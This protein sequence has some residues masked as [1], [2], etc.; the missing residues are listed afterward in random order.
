VAV[1][2]LLGAGGF[3]AVWEAGEGSS[4][5][6]KVAHH[7]ASSRDSGFEKEAEALTRVGPPHTPRL[8]EAGV[9]ADGRPYLLQE[10][11]DT[12]SL[13]AMLASREHP[14]EGDALLEAAL[15][16]VEA[17]EAMHAANVLHRDLKPENIF[18]KGLPP[19]AML[20]D[21][22]TA[23]SLEAERGV[24]PPGAVGS[25]E[26]MSPE[27]LGSEEPLGPEADLYA[28]GVILFELATLRLPFTGNAHELEYAH[29]NLRPLRPSQF[30][31]VG[32]GL[33]D[34]IL[35]CLQ[36]RPSQR[37]P[38]ASA[39]KAALHQ[40][41]S[42]PTSTAPQAKGPAPAPAGGRSKLTAALV[43]F[44][45][46]HDAASLQKLIVSAGGHIAHRSGA[47]CVA[48]FTPE[49][50]ENLGR[51]ALHC[52]STLV[53]RGACQKALVDLAP[54]LVSRRPEGAVL[55]ASPTFSQPDRYPSSAD[56]DGILV[57][58]A[59]QEAIGDIEGEPCAERAGH[60]LYRRELAGEVHLTSAAKSAKLIGREALVASLLDEVARSLKAGESAVSMVVGAPGMGKSHLAR[61]V[62]DRLQRTSPGLRT[63]R[64]VAREPVGRSADE[65][66]KDFLTRVLELPAGI[67]SEE[68]RQLVEARL[69]DLGAA[70][71]VALGLIFGWVAPDAPEVRALRAAPGA[72]QAALARAGGEAVRRLVAQGPVCIWLDD[73]QWF[74]TV[75]LEALDQ[76]SVASGGLHVLA[77]GRPESAE[78]FAS[79]GRRAR[80]AYRHE[81]AS[82]DRESAFE[83]CRALLLP[84]ALVA[85]TD[86]ERIVDRV[87]GV[88]LLMVELVRGLK[89][90]GLLRRPD[91][92]GAWYVAAE[93]LDTIP[94]LPLLE[95]LTLRQMASLTADLAA[96]ARLLAVLSPLVGPA[97]VEGVLA[98]LEPEMAALFP[99]D[100]RAGLY[101]LREAKVVV[102]H[103]NGELSLRSGLSSAVI[104][105][106]LPKPTLTCI[107]RAALRYYQ[108]ASSADSV[109][110]P[111]LAFHAALA[112]EKQ[113]AMRTCLQLAEQARARHHYLEA[114][115]YYSR[116]AEH[117]VPGHEAE[118]L[119]VYRGRGVVR[120]RAG[121]V[122]DSLGDFSR[123]R[124]LAAARGDLLAQTEVLLDESMA[125]DWMN[126][127]H[128]SKL[129][130]EEAK[131][132]SPTPAPALLSARI[133]QA[134]GRSAC[135]FS[136]DRA[137]VSLYREAAD[138]AQGLGEDAYEVR[139]SV[140]VHLGFVLP[141][142]GHLDEAE[143]RLADVEAQALAHGDELH[144]G[145]MYL[146]RSCLWIA[147]NDR[148][149]FLQDNDKLLALA[150]RL[151]NAFLERNANLNAAYFLHW[152]GEHEAAEPFVR[153][154][155]EI[156]EQAFRL[157]GRPEGEVL[158]ARILFARG[159]LAESEAL[160]SKVETH[161]QRAK[162][163]GKLDLLIGPNDEVLLDA[164]R[165]AVRG[166]TPAAWRQ[167][168]ERGRQLAQGQEILELLELRG[169]V[170]EQGGD[171]A[172][173]RAAW[174]EALKI[175]KDLPNVLA[176]R[177]QARL[178]RLPGS[179]D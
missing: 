35:R 38:S 2:R 134:L 108:G 92:G 36:K 105:R 149:R 54:V 171:V 13:A 14:W 61:T 29:R 81:L 52:A 8:L 162:A 153:R 119:L 140:N 67:S 58:A 159:A 98:A 76:A 97:E 47:Q 93:V 53:A 170:A 37:Y 94:D 43:Y 32:A 167:V 163:E 169:V 156:T 131:A 80:K 166:G 103:S 68:C 1:G 106:P 30:A 23:S 20:I 77:F 125:L 83:L 57:S 10:R 146:N 148:E 22:G 133:L 88:P 136:Q 31:P 178:A 55:I 107:H 11:I 172:S 51:V 112:G 18:L 116:C 56:P 157:G 60:V 70:V 63:L 9:L 151:G 84:A 104:A 122:T 127:W 138:I 75:T 44:T 69:G 73:L 45:S 7:P 90:D 113:L 164:A 62:V 48:A 6:L 165:L 85:Q 65:T 129:L 109:R 46:E 4:L 118:Q 96:H 19:R 86:L 150:G 91:D 21:F 78:I 141:F 42:E 95:W 168:L 155:I 161:Q 126:E 66:L 39:L 16:L 50:G 79:F 143:H 34:V 24:T 174:E 40:A 124:E 144:L 111:R 59:A 28:L 89:R 101:Q 87:E 27:Q 33:E 49:R 117:L 177:V 130:A 15:A 173:A 176:P 154:M 139:T 115:L 120:Y 100:A 12:P 71:L 64:V 160:I 26:Y 145:A 102:E 82:L 128:R 99:L 74:D 152:R 132:K 158:L 17:V 147:R 110:L 121:R 5:A 179:P 175:G 25:R 3:A 72:L 142:L 114:E 137:G 123:A 41:R 135:R